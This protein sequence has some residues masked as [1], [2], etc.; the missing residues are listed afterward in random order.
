MFI[1]NFIHMNNL[2]NMTYID[3][4]N[5]IVNTFPIYYNVFNKYYKEGK[6]VSDE[7]NRLYKP[8]FS[9]LVNYYDE[10][11]NSGIID[12][13]QDLKNKFN[14]DKSYAIIDYLEYLFGNIFYE[15]FLFEIK[16]IDSS[17]IRYEHLCVFEYMIKV[18][19]VKYEEYNKVIEKLKE[20]EPESKMIIAMEHRITNCIK[21]IS[22]CINWI[23]KNYSSHND[24]IELCIG[25]VEEKELD[26]LLDLDSV[27]S[28]DSFMK[29]NSK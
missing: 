3:T 14:P 21:K 5:K 12:I 11:M 2:S 10:F 8:I 16:K 1:L 13:I 6:D 7:L 17:I 9:G 27:S 22:F 19:C 25:I 23:K 28:L 4:Y 29:W 18:E 20:F 24:F 15:T 26:K